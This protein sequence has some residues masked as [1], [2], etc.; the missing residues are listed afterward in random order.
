[1]SFQKNLEKYAK[2]VVEVGINVQPGQ[3][4]VINASIQVADFVRKI[5]KRAYEVGAKHVYVEWQDEICT[6]LKY[7]LAPDEAFNEYPMWK[8]EGM[9]T[10]AE[11]GGA[12]LYIEST[13]P[14][15]LKGVNPE[16]I[17]NAS[18]VAGSAL[19]KFR[20]YTLADKISWSIVAAP[21]PAW[22]KKVF[23]DKN[24]EDAMNALWNAIFYATRVDQED[25]V[26][27]WKKHNANLHEKVAFLNKKRYKKLHYRAPGTELTVELPDTHIWCGGST[28][29]SD[30][31]EFNPNLPTEEVFT[32]PISG[33]TQGVVRSTKPLSYKGN[34]IE[35]FM[36]EFQDGRV[37]NYE[38]EIG[39]ESLKQ[40]IELDEGAHYLGEIALVPHDSPISNSNLTFFSTL[41]DENAS[42]HLA[43]GAG[44]SSSIE[45]G[46]EMSKEELKEAG[47]ND[48]MTHVDFMI[49][50]AEMDI[51]GETADGTKEPVFRKGNWAF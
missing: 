9:T 26:A 40:M 10:I 11:E 25:P 19:Q 34:L 38:A 5:V 2:L 4:M 35:N 15:L 18:R 30:G 8:A 6:R 33:R 14:E 28:V 23:P 31:A 3:T 47:I 46:T 29:N 51:D 39:H 43:I 36:L 42:N 20:E 45:G 12:Y 22:A 1:M 27:I 13:D 16:R 44:F 24:E 49:G 17:G 48:S 7:D 32:S 37:V 21:G 50:S 41:F